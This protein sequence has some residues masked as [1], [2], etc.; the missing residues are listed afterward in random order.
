MT[1]EVLYQ[2]MSLGERVDWL[3]KRVKRLENPGRTHFVGDDCPG[4]HITAEQVARWERIERAAKT[5]AFVSAGDSRI[6]DLREALR[7]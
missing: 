2:T 3:A 5:V 1:D 7:P 6:N 4:A